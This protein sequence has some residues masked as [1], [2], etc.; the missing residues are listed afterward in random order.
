GA[1]LIDV[2]DDVGFSSRP[3]SELKRCVVVARGADAYRAIFSWNELYNS[4]LGES[5]LVLYER[6]GRPLADDLGPLS[7]ISARD[8]QFGPRHLR[9]LR[10]LHVELLL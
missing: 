4:T 1:R 2:L 5:V 9:D 10:A 3:R 8:R 7:L 6:D